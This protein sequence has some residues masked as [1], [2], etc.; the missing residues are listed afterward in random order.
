MAC[1]KTGGLAPSTAI[2]TAAGTVYRSDG[3]AQSNARVKL[4]AHGTS[5]LQADLSTDALGNFYTTASVPAMVTAA[6]QQF[7]VG[8]DVVITTSARRVSK[9][10]RLQRWS[11]QV[12]RNSAWWHPRPSPVLSITS[13]VAMAT[14]SREQS[15]QSCIWSRRRLPIP[16]RISTSW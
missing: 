4:Y 6:G 15:A 1:H 2:F 13:G 9:C 10:S 5:N 16:E 14:K 12:E 8:V 3:S 7:A 11:N